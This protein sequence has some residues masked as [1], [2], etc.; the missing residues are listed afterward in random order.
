MT[1]V[2]GKTR[3]AARVINEVNG[4]DY[5]YATARADATWDMLVAAIASLE[6]KA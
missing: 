6:V 3:E 5:T 4:T 1:A 2:N